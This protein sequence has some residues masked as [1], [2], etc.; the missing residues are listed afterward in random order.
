[1]LSR[2]SALRALLKGHTKPLT[3]LAFAPAGAGGSNGGSTLL[4]SGAADGQLYVWQLRV[5]QDEGII[6]D[7]QKLH[8]SFV[9]GG[10]E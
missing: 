1:M 9:A 7:T 2:S 10:G 8:A 3:D 5:D 4:A 6:R